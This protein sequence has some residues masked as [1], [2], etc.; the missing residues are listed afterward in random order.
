MTGR[1]GRKETAAAET[2]KIKKINIY[3]DSLP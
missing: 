3:T 1:G 2:D